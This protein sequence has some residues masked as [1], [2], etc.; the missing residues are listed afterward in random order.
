MNSVAQCYGGAHQVGLELLGAA[1]VAEHA[2]VLEQNFG[3]QN[4]TLLTCFLLKVKPRL[5]IGPLTLASLFE[6]R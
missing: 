6:L 3:Q 5:K 2:E 4:A 1:S